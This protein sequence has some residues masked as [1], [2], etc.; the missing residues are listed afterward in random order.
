YSL[1][2]E[3]SRRHEVHIYCREDGFFDQELREVDEVYHGLPVR[4]IYF[5]LVGRKANPLNQ[6]FIRIKNGLIERS[7]E[8]FLEETSPHIV[9]VQHLF[10]LSAGLIPLTRKRGI[11]VV[12]TL[13]DFW[14]LCHNVLLLRPGQKLCS[15]PAWGLKCPGCAELNVSPLIR[16]LLNPL[17]TPLFIYR[18]AYLKRC[19]QQADVV[20]S[21]SAFVKKKL[22]E[23]GYDGHRILVSDYGLRTDIRRDFNRLPSDKLRVGYIGTIQRHKGVHILI[24]AFN[25]LKDY[26]A[27]LKIYGNPNYAPRYYARVQEMARNPAIQFYG[28][29][30]NADI[31]RVLANIDVVVIPSIWYENSPLAI[32]EANAVKIPVLASNIGGMAEL[33]QDGVTG[34][35]F[36]VGS[37]D[38]LAAKI[39]L[40]VEDRR[41]L[42]RL[43]A[44]IRSVKSIEEN[45]RELEAIYQELIARRGL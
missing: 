5:N 45:A 39:R 44:N 16:A 38:D 23:N 32:H 29:V 22:V 34:L 14:Y 43:R 8:R 35:L 15:G 12:V 9:H 2:R 31:G 42:E 13:A 27:E 4:R 33:V 11:P 1:A 36:Q 7:F 17:M 25:R 24:E 37:A 20:I 28:E 41:L 21:P 3:L 18:N 19:L 30:D 40:L 10:K 26:A 6:F